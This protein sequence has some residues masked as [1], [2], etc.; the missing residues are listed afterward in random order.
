MYI[1][2]L[3]TFF[4]LSSLTRQILS[5]GTMLIDWLLFLFEIRGRETK[6]KSHLSLSFSVALIYVQYKSSFVIRWASSTTISVLLFVACLSLHLSLSLSLG[7]LPKS[8]AKRAERLRWMMCWRVFILFYQRWV[9]ASRRC[10]IEY[11]RVLFSPFFFVTLVYYYSCTIQN[12]NM[13]WMG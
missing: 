2:W 9:M 3:F 5:S 4:F 1:L 7:P 6:K 13:D 8:W 12:N 10:R 11:S